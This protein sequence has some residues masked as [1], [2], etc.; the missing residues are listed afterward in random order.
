MWQ[1]P[2]RINFVPIAQFV[3]F[4][5]LTC[6][7]NI[8]WQ[9]YMESKFPGY[10]YDFYGTLSLDRI[11][12][13]KKLILD[14]TVGAMVNTALFLSG[15]AALKGKKPRTIAR[16]VERDFWP[17]I[18]NGWKV[19]P[20]VPLFNFSIVPVDKRVLVGSIFGLFWGIYLSLFAS[21][22]E[23]VTEEDEMVEVRLD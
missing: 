19:W 13:A 3:F 18:R 8:L 10:T 14:Q 16:D 22:D 7:P 20:L 5:F 11:N 17:L 4:T 12:T 1:V 21:R 2:F 9:Q 23:P 6:P 15:M